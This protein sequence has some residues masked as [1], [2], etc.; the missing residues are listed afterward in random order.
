VSSPHVKIRPLTAFLPRCVGRP[1]FGEAAAIVPLLV[2]GHKLF[3]RLFDLNSFLA[4]EK[5]GSGWF[6]KYVQD[7][8]PSRPQKRSSSPPLPPV[9][10]NGIVAAASTPTPKV[11]RPA[12]TK[13]PA[14]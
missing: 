1:L 7:G 5:T 14:R 11:R 2:T 3:V 12:R 4:R 8:E 9:S 6:V 10:D 13:A